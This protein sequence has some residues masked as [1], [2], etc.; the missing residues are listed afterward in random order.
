LARS[1]RETRNDV[2]RGVESAILDVKAVC[3]VFQRRSRYVV[4][5]N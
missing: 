1:E 5:K 3:V 2:G 4:R